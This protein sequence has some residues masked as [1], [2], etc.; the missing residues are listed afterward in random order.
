M[1]ISRAILVR[2]RHVSDKS[3]VQ[4]FFSPRKPFRLSDNVEKYG[5]AGQAV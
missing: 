4:P 1:I 2:I 3:Y 5:T